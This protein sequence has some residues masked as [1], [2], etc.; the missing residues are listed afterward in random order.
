[1]ITSSSP[2]LAKLT[3]VK[4]WD[5]TT[6]STLTTGLGATSLCEVRGGLPEQGLAGERNHR[7]RHATFDRSECV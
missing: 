3:V 1:V 4:K 2:T 6:F 5:G 7:D